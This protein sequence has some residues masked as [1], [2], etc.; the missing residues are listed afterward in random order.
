M[1]RLD[2][3]EAFP[4]FHEGR[5]RTVYRRGEGPPVI[6]IHEMPGITPEVARFARRVADR[7]FTVFLPSLFGRDGG[8]ATGGAFLAAFAQICISREFALLAENRAG[9]VVDWLR[10]LARHVHSMLGGRG[11]GIVGMCLTGNFALTM[12]L[13]PEVVA[14]VLAQPSLPIPSIGRKASALHAPPEA[15]AAIRRRYAEDGLKVVGLRFKGDRKCPP[16]RF[17]TLRLELGEAFEGHELEDESAASGRKRPH[18]VLTAELIDE[19]GEPTR[20]A[21]E[22]VLGYFDERLRP[23]PP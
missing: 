20:V 14:P 9:P 15:L 1:D 5:L 18:S 17:E 19:E 22:R 11:V 10:G 16:E 8:Q 4:F 21:L 12:A 13:D 23:T 7:G 2:D 3:F 6:I